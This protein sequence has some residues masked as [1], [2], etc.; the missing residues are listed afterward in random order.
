V[1]PEFPP[2][3]VI[4]APLAEARGAAGATATRTLSRTATRS[5][6]GTR[7]AGMLSQLVPPAYRYVLDALSAEAY[8]HILRQSE[9]LLVLHTPPLFRQWPGCSF[10]AAGSYAAAYQNSELP[11]YQIARLGDGRTYLVS[12]AE[13]MYQRPFDAFL[14][15]QPRSKPGSDTYEEYCEHCRLWDE[16][17]PRRRDEYAREADCFNA[18]L[19]APGILPSVREVMWLAAPV[20]A[21]ADA[22]FFRPI[23]SP[24][25]VLVHVL[26]RGAAQPPSP[27]PLAQATSPQPTPPVLCLTSQ[28]ASN[29]PS[30]EAVAAALHDSASDAEPT[31]YISPQLAAPTPMSSRLH[32]P[33]LS[34]SGR[35]DSSHAGASSGAPPR[36]SCLAQPLSHAASSSSTT[37]GADLVAP[38][39][40]R[41]GARRKSTAAHS[42]SKR[43]RGNNT[44]A[45]DSPPAWSPAPSDPESAPHPSL[46]SAGCALSSVH[47]T[48]YEKFPNAPPSLPTASDAS[49]PPVSGLSGLS[50][51]RPPALH[52]HPPYSNR[53]AA[54]GAAH[55]AAAHTH[56]SHP[57][58]ALASGPSTPGRARGSPSHSNPPHMHPAPDRSTAVDWLRHSAAQTD[59]AL[60]CTGADTGGTEGLLSPR[61]RE[62]M[63][64][65]RQ[66]TDC[67]DPLFLQVL[68]FEYGAEGTHTTAAMHTASHMSHST[69]SSPEPGTHASPV[70][71]E[72]ENPLDDH[73]ASQPF[74]PATPIADQPCSLPPDVT[75][76]PF[77]PATE[78]ASQPCSLT[79][80]D[81]DQPLSDAQEL[82]A[83]PPA[84]LPPAQPFSHAPEAASPPRSLPLRHAQPYSFATEGA[85]P[86]CSVVPSQPFAL[87]SEDA[88][89]LLS[90]PPAQPLP[91]PSEAADQP[92]SLATEDALAMYAESAQDSYAEPAHNRVPDS[93]SRPEPMSVWGSDTAS[94]PD[95]SPDAGPAEVHDIVPQTCAGAPACSGDVEMSAVCDTHACSSDM[96]TSAGC[97]AP[98]CCGGMEVGAPA[99]PVGSAMDITSAVC[100]APA[101]SGMD[102]NAVAGTPTRSGMAQTSGGVET[103]YRTQG[104]PRAP[105]IE[106]ANLLLSIGA[107]DRASAFF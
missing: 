14:A 85:S 24:A 57:S 19:E 48:G 42:A 91:P 51:V 90:P 8:A 5:A 50:P 95:L 105:F 6:L 65:I 107:S 58:L 61:L 101:C 80:E 34:P 103:S 99:M 83:S 16:L 20:K 72:Y 25:R 53:S 13:V 31:P 77:S 56:T 2:A 11:Y 52:M 87:S 54:A 30:P 73:G 46:K 21:A 49:N 62:A 88:T 69:T 84:A 75:A 81:A 4:G 70:A 22:V 35:T 44:R 1:L 7:G 39:G 26:I 68:D 104:E 15:R 82:N 94:H 60:P 89:Q 37:G 28:V 41:R 67:L 78:T 36:S 10:L 86:A 92:Y 79:P 47:D 98:A 96:D 93:S 29:L 3:L 12:R 17:D 71:P 64:A 45:A 59:A 63:Q 100:C 106:E 102:V 9:H 40:Q 18:R 32:E 33:R 43:G 38:A 55:H 76:Q 97:C 74:T 27:S 66:A 23:Q